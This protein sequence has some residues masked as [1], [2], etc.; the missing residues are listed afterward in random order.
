[1]DDSLSIAE[2]RARIPPLRALAPRVG[3]LT[4]GLP[5]HFSRNDFH[6]RSGRSSTRGAPQ[7]GEG[8]SKPVAPI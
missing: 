7:L 5:I 3:R 8:R 2:Q 6:D 1:M 4:L